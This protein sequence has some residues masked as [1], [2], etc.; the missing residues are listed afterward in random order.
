[1]ARTIFQLDLVLICVTVLL[2]SVGLLSLYSLS[3]S[4][5]VN[6]FLKQSIFAVLGLGAMFFAAST[7]YRH[8]QKY[9]T[10][11]YFATA[12][13]LLGV[14]LFGTTVNGTAGW[15]SFGIFQV[16]PVEVAKVTLI[17]FLASFISKKN[18]ELGEWTRVIASLVLTVLLVF[19]V[20]KQPDLG[21]ALVLTAIWGGMILA[22]GLRLKHLIVLGI[23]GALL[24]SA[25]WFALA[26][27]QKARIE[28]FLHPESDPQGTGYNVLQAMVAV[29]S[30]GISGKGL[31]YGS[32][33]QL[34]FLPE[35]HTDFIFAVVSEELGLVGALFV[36]SLYAVLL[37]RIR[38][39]GALASDNFGYL[40]ALGVMV[41]IFVQVLVNVGMNVG[42][43]PVTGIPAPLLSY[44]GSSFLSVCFSL[45][46]LLSIYLR[47]P[48][49]T[50]LRLSLEKSFLEEKQGR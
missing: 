21:S 20:L 2:L 24:I 12:S 5:G 36:I 8:L 16:Q 39:I 38:R 43:L 3:S 34:S 26:P 13:V 9:S 25:S 37:Y 40:I 48:G 29:G 10:A 42:L 27:Y 49:E 14:L 19:L 15:L 4:G 31:G 1:M 30:G 50:D 6:Y 35:K 23:C 41:M 32:Q 44:G 7:D 46:L 47:K 28:V 17:I 22:S 45:G 11:L 18:S 33:S